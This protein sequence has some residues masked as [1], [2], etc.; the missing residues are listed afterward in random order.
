[1]NT[2]SLCR[3]IS[4]GARVISPLVLRR[5]SFAYFLCFLLFLLRFFF[6]TFLVAFLRP[7]SAVRWLCDFMD[8]LSPRSTLAPVLGE[9]GRLFCIDCTMPAMWLYPG[10]DFASGSVKNWL[11]AS[12]NRC[13]ARS[14][15]GCS[16]VP[17]TRS[18]IGVGA[19]GGKSSAVFLTMCA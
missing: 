6:F 9:L 15:Q 18:L 8:V 2:L 16:V 11:H 4:T 7:A 10:S 13:V 1:M 19:P 14:R 5:L 17:A 12:T 3:A